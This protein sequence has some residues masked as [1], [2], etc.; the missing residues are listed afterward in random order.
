MAD[1]LLQ[2]RN[3]PVTSTPAVNLFTADPTAN[4]KDTIYSHTYTCMY[5]ILDAEWNEH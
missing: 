5:I 3:I 2:V 4:T 1:S